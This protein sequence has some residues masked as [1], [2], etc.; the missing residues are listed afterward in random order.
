MMPDNEKTT[1]LPTPTPS[2][3]RP[4]SPLPALLL[5]CAA[6]GFAGWQAYDNHR[7]FAELRQDQANAV[8]EAAESA[9]ASTQRLLARLEAAETKLA[10]FSSDAQ[11]LQDFRQEIS[12]GRE[13]ATLLD[14]E[15][16]VTLAVQQL[17]IA[18]NVQVARLA[19]QAADARLARLERPQL[20]P[21]RKALAKDI[22]RLNA[23]P[24]VDVPGIS[25]RLE[26]VVVAVD[27]LPLAAYGRPARTQEKKAAPA[28]STGLQGRI[29]KL[30]AELSG[31]IRI[32]RFDEEDAALLAP[33]QDFFLRENLKLRLLNARLALLAR[34]QSVYRAEMR[35][36]QDWLAKYFVDDDK[37]VQNALATLSQAAPANL[38]VELPTLNDSQAALRSLRSGGKEKP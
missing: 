19:L 25:L 26:Q 4:I 38:N 21:L 33:G 17:Q 11:A 18:G 2:S 24:F 3:R 6:L 16:A 32:Q 7:Q 8:A 27:K 28:A 37:A 5:A 22:E 23:L 9:A 36:A 34:D 20:L 35:Q 30:W 14:V 15:Q 12:Q 13:A 31:L 1:S 29:D 10:A